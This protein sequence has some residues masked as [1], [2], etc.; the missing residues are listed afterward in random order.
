MPAMLAHEARD[1]RQAAR[2][3]LCATA[4]SPRTGVAGELQALQM[5]RDAP[6]F[7]PQLGGP[8]AR[9]GVLVRAEPRVALA[10]APAAI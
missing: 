6:E 4:W 1:A 7:A 5:A 9:P 8:A 3:A 2:R 10:A